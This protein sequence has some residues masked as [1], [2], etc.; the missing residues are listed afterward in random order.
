MNNSEFSGEPQV[1]PLIQALFVDND[2][3]CLESLLDENIQWHATEPRRDYSGLSQVRDHI[4]SQMHR[5]R[6]TLICTTA[7][8]SSALNDRYRLITVKALMQ[9]K[10]CHSLILTLIQDQESGK[11]CFV[12]ICPAQIASEAYQN[13]ELALTFLP[14]QMPGGIFHC[15]FDEP[16]TLLQTSDSFLQ[17]TGYTREEIR[18]ELHNSFRALID[19]RDYENTLREVREQLRHGCDK[20]LQFRLL[21]KNAEP[22]WV[23]D[24]GRYLQD[25]WGRQYFCCI[26]VDISESKRIAEEFRLSLQRYEIIM[27]QTQDIIFEWN[28]AT[29][30]LTFSE[31]WKQYLGYPRQITVSGLLDEKNTNFYPEQRSLFADLCRRIRAGQ[32]YIEDELQLHD[33]HHQPNWFRIR[34]TTQ[35]DENQKPIKAIGILSNIDEDKRSA[36]AVL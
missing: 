36:D 25:E 17:L 6:E 23:L 12:Q 26:L 11:F 24:K 33:V 1:F 16:L 21:R 10:D 7:P 3:T 35:L 32:A 15:L 2:W 28:I 18:T 30:E 31:N 34:V 14:D 22:I 4:E 13:Q 27:N 8:V 5:H 29:D 20:E 19:P 9:G